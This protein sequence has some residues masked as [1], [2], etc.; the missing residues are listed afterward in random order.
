MPGSSVCISSSHACTE[1][2]H[3][4]LVLPGDPD[5]RRSHDC[6]RL[7]GIA[8]RYPTV[9]HASDVEDVQTRG[10]SGEKR[11]DQRMHLREWA[12]ATAILSIASL[13]RIGFS[14]ACARA[15]NSYTPQP[16]AVSRQEAG[17]LAS[18]AI[19]FLWGLRNS[20]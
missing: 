16:V 6:S 19:E 20:K 2:E 9:D 1:R 4:P 18:V 11:T 17:D 5:N 8:E 3:V 15:S 12:R 10:K 13:R 14:M 7:L